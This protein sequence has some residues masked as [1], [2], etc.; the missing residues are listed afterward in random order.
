MLNNDMAMLLGG[1]EEVV[2]EDTKIVE[3]TIQKASDEELGIT[4]S[5]KRYMIGVGKY[6]GLQ[7]KYLG[8]EKSLEGS[9]VNIEIYMEDGTTVKRNIPISIFKQHFT[10]IVGEGEVLC[11]CCKKNKVTDANI[12]F[13]NVCLNMEGLPKQVLKRIENKDVCAQ[14]QKAIAFRDTEEGK[15]P[16]ALKDLYNNAKAKN[17]DKIAKIQKLKEIREAKN[18]PHCESCGSIV[19]SI[20]LNELKEWTDVVGDKVLCA[21]CLLEEVQK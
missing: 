5:E 6:K 15:K 12:R 8:Y 7:A 9:T 21:N 14:C 10:L 19:T 18:K 13:L 20:E 3:D 4:K 16:I 17:K 2:V 1:E 11:S